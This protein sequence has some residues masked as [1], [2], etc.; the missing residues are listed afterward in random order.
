[1]EPLG[2]CELLEVWSLP[3]LPALHLHEARV[4][5]TACRDLLQTDQEARV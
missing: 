1:M 4:L 5:L 2:S 3:F